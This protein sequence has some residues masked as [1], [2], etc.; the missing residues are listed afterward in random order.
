VWTVPSATD[1][2]AKFGPPE[3][4]GYLVTIAATAF[5][6]GDPNGAQISAFKLFV[7]SDKPAAQRAIN[8]TIQSLDVL[9][10]GRSLAPD[11]DDR[12]EAPGDSVTLEARPE[13][14]LGALTYH[15]FA[16][17]EDFSPD[18]DA[19]QKFAPGDHGAYSIYLVLRQSYFFRH[20][21]STSTRVAGED[22]RRIE[23]VFGGH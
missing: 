5:A 20:D 10:G 17:D 6:N 7:I 23:V 15:W 4:N 21:D 18:L 13:R 16:T 14:D 9:S 12:Y 22:W 8:P 11:A 1:L 2:R 3:K 19:K